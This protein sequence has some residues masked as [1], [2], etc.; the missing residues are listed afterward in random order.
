MNFKTQCIAIICD[1][2]RCK[3]YKYE[4]TKFCRLHQN[5]DSKVSDDNESQILTLENQSISIRMK[6]GIIYKHK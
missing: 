6:N 5:F 1:N 3:R 2:S 4:D